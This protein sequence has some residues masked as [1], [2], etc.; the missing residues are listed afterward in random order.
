MNAMK[1]SIVIFAIAFSGLVLCNGCALFLIG[2]AAAAGAGTVIY[3]DGQLK[4]TEP[5]SLDHAHAA[6]L[7]GLVAVPLTGALLDATGSWELVFA[8]TAAHYVAGAAVFAA[9]SGAEPLPEDGGD[10]PLPAARS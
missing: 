9:W 6:T 3:L 1:N 8:L 10:A 7:A 2:G 5:A 4:D